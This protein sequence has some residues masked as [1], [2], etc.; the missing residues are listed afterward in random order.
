MPKSELE[1][2]EGF[3]TDV[4]MALETLRARSVSGVTPEM[5]DKMVAAIEASAME[6]LREAVGV[7]L[8]VTFRLDDLPRLSPS[9]PVDPLADE[10][11]REA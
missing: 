5:V 2:R 11:G 3:R 9:L 4:R 6:F 8:E 1:L 10:A 7:G